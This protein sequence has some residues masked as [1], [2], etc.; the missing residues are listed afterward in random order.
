MKIKMI[1]LL[2]ALAGV[3][4]AHAENI[5]RMSAPVVQGS[6]WQTYQSLYSDWVNQ[7]E[8]EHCTGVA[9]SENTIEIGMSFTQTVSGCSQNQVQ[10]VTTQEINKK[11]QEIRPTGTTEKTRLLENYSYTRTAM[12]LDVVWESAPPAYSGWTNVGASTGCTGYTPAADTVILGEAFSQTLSGCTQQQSQTVTAQQKNK[13]TNQIRA[14][15]SS[16]ANQTLT[17]YSYTVTAIGTKSTKSCQAFNASSGATRMMWEEAARQPDAKPTNGYSLTW[18]GTILFNNM[19]ID[20]TRPIRTEFVIGEYKY[21]RGVFYNISGYYP[22]G[23]LNRINY[24]ICREK[25]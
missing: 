20:N 10:Q 17:D 22:E 13:Y 6:P 21:T 2:V 16:V 23:N 11:T 3:N 14:T 9:P 25:I 24:G 12:G 8:S 1:A 18:A 4:A 5:I 7:G 19:N 15:G